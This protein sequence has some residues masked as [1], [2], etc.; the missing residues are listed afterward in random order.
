MAYGLAE[1]FRKTVVRLGGKKKN[2]ALVIATFGN[3]FSM[4]EAVEKFRKEGLRF[5]TEKDHIVKI[6]LD[7]N[8]K[9]RAEQ[10]RRIIRE[11]FGYVEPL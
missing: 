10:V 9:E 11:H 4:N 1:G 5:E 2:Q 6:Y 7:K 3:H 8:T